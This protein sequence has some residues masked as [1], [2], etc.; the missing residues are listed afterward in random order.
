MTAYIWASRPR[1][2]ILHRDTLADLERRG[3][4]AV[5][6]IVGKLTEIPYSSPEIQTAY[7]LRRDAHTT[8]SVTRAEAESWL[9]W[10]AAQD[11]WWI[12]MGVFAAFLAAV[13]SALSWLVPIR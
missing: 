9:R 13:L 8:V 3:V 12:R 5:T 1:R 10:K 2:P 4:P 7:E 11:G 6:A